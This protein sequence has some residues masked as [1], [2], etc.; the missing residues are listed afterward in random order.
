MKGFF[1]KTNI[2][3]IIMFTV[4]LS[5]CIGFIYL[6]INNSITSGEVIGALCH[7]V[8]SILVLAINNQKIKRN[9]I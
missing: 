6:I 7:Y 1:S 4:A 9:N 2:N 8:Y 3:N 5:L